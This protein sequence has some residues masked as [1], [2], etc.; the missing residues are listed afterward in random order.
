MPMPWN[1]WG[2]GWWGG[3]V[4]SIV[5]IVF[6]IV[7]VLLIVWAVRHWGAG[8]A[9]QAGPPQPPAPPPSPLQTPPP[10]SQWTAAED[11]VSVVKRR[12]AAGE[13]DRDE[14]L[15]KLSDL[16]APPSAGA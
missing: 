9:G 3:W 13:I 14:Y 5:Q 16:G 11:A 10:P 4:Q 1:W 7:V 15:Q 2:G 6:W 12:Y 8:G